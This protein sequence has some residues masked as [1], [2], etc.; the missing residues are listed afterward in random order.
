ML[1]RL[2]LAA[3]LLSSVGCLEPEIDP[4]SPALPAETVGEDDPAP[5]V[6][7][8]L[9]PAA[10]Y[11]EGSIGGRG[12]FS[13]LAT[14]ELQRDLQRATNLKVAQTHDGVGFGMV[15][16]RSQLHGI[17]WYAA[18]EYAIEIPVGLDDDDSL[19]LCSGASDTAIGFD[20]FVAGTMTVS[21]I[22]NG[23][24]FDFFTTSSLGEEVRGGFD[25][26]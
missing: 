20:E 16:F 23:R 7:L 15:W 3:A 2:F 12:K 1:T 26:Y 10:G 25:L 4:P 8:T 17:Q 18:G 9:E 11:V 6:S 22:E 19:T 5:S 14:V 24:R 13:G 21:D